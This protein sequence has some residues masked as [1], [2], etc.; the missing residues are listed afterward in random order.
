[1]RTTILTA[2]LAAAMAAAPVA[3]D[4]IG[5]VLSIARRIGYESGYIAPRRPAPPYVAP[6]GDFQYGPAGQ[7][8]YYSYYGRPYAG[9]RRVVG[10]VPGNF[11]AVAGDQL[12][13]MDY[14]QLR[15]AALATSTEF[16]Q[17]LS[18]IPAGEVWIK[19]F[20]VHSLEE[21]LAST[22]T[23]EP[24][25]AERDVVVRVLGIFD[26]AVASTDMDDLTRT[27]S[28]RRLHALLRELA[29]SPDQ[30]LM[31]QLSV[32]ARSLNRVLGAF[33]TGVTWQR[34]LALPDGIIAAADRPPG[35]AERRP[36]FDAAELARIVDR[37]DVVSRSSDYSTIAALPEFQ[38]THQRLRELVYPP[39]Q[40]PAPAAVAEQL[41]P[42]QLRTE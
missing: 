21:S 7:G 14:Q 2:S 18:S 9:S 42:P 35:E 16:N 39:S 5:E 11:R 27:D 38:A 4:P 37:F 36:E 40:E 15:S 19:H 10:Y 25:A 34:Y 29:T 31:R 20:D 26:R 13:Q 12:L 28:A 24:T 6:N 1:M 30:R 41:P 22:A 33:N 3:A 32:N 23:G 17:W 8:S